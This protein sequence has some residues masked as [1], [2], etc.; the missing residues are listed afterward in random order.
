MEEL[1]LED[2]DSGEGADDQESSDSDVEVIGA[3]RKLKWRTSQ[4]RK[5]YVAGLNAWLD[6]KYDSPE[7]M[8]WNITKDWILSPED[9]KHMARHPGLTNIKTL[10]TLRPPWMHLDRWG[11]E[12]LQVIAQATAVL[13]AE[14]E[15]KRR[16]AEEKR[17]AAEE[18]ARVKE[19][20]RIEREAE[21]QRKIEEALES[22]AQAAGA[23]RKRRVALPK[24]A[25]PEEVAIRAQEVAEDNR[26]RQRE[27]YWANEG[28]RQQKQIKIEPTI[29]QDSPQA[30]PS[31]PLAKP[32]PSRRPA[33][34]TTYDNQI[35]TFS[36]KQEILDDHE[37][38]LG[39]S[40]T[41]ATS[42]N[43]PIHCGRHA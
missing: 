28:E 39:S 16:I 17:L 40:T 12:I 13:E 11:D 21:R 1:N 38:I 30:G 33:K 6:Q 8:H 24:T 23:P 20:N 2:L 36:A 25:T 42:S 22:K 26:R 19:E 29:E 14:Q 3:T 5:P 27:R 34:S 15:S 43:L 31:R 32:K 35:V 10:A 4:E 37:H 18:T 7:C 41:G 9:I